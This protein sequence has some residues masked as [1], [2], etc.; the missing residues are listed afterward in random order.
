MAIGSE[1]TDLVAYMLLFVPLEY[2]MRSRRVNAEGDRKKAAIRSLC[3][4]VLAASVKIGFEL[5]NKEPSYYDMMEVLPSAPYAELKKGFKRV[6]LK[7]HPDK[8]MAAG[9]SDGAGDDEDDGSEAFRRLK[10]AYDVLS[11]QQLRDLYNKFG[12]PG[13]KNKDDTS[14]LLAGLGFFYVMWLAAAYLL[15]QSKPVN[16]AQTWGFSGLVALAIF[17][18]QASR[19]IA[20]L[21]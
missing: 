19:E 15:T 10:A 4:L 17:E 18:Y 7:V 14:G 12:T 2:L 20:C 3:L 21:V 5:K 11:D 9:G 13:V 8:V 6:S 1:G 16:R